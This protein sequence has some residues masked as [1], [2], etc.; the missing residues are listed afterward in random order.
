MRFGEKEV[1]KW[2]LVMIVTGT[3]MFVSMFLNVLN[4]TFLGE[5]Y[6]ISG[7][8]LMRGGF[9]IGFVEIGSESLSVLR[10]IPLICSI[11]GAAV[12]I[13]SV[14]TAYL[15]YD[16]RRL[17]I[18]V[19][20]TLTVTLLLSVIFLMGGASVEIFSGSAKDLLQGL[21]AT[22][23]PMYGTYIA[24]FS[25]FVCGMASTYRMRECL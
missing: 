12:V 18:A 11:I 16:S 1:S 7:L 8:D 20:L 19:S 14:V 23:T 21:L 5:S 9:N 2:T 17:M 13:L 6:G 10:Y 22:V 3:F 15:E 24:V 4:V 25:T